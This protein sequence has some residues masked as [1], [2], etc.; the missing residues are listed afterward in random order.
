MTS[1]SRLVRLPLLTVALAV[2]PSALAAQLREGDAGERAAY[3]R[4]LDAYPYADEPPMARI[5]AFESLRLDAPRAPSV[6]QPGGRGRFTQLGPFAVVQTDGFYLSAPQ[7]DAGRVTSIALHPTLP[8]TYYAGTAGG[9]LWKTTNGGFTWQALTD[10]ECGKDIG[11]VVVD[12][13]N[14]E[15]VYAGMGNRVE[16]P[17]QAC[18]LLR[19]T[20]GGESWTRL[21]ATQFNQRR[22]WAMH[23]DP[24]TAGSVSSAVLLVG[25]DIGLWRSTNGGTAFTQVRTG[26]HSAVAGH[27]ANGAIM[28]AARYGF[29]STPAEVVRSTD[30]GAT[31]SVIADALPVAEAGRVEL[32]TSAADPDALWI[33]AERRSDARLLGLYRWHPATGLTT[34]NASGLFPGGPRLDFGAQTW[35]NLAL[36]VDPVDAQRIYLGGVRAYRSNDGGN[37]F[38]EMARSI[39]VDWHTIVVHPTDPRRIFAGNDGGLVVSTDRGDNFTTRNGGMATMMFYPGIAVHPTIPGY[40]LG[41]TQDNGSM[42]SGFFTVFEGVSGGDGGFAAINPQNPSIMWTT[43]QQAGALGCLYR[44]SG[45]T[46]VNRS[47]GISVGDRHGF[48]APLVMSPADPTRLYYGTQRLWRTTNEGLAWN[49]RSGDLT[50]G[51]GVITTIVEAPSASGVVWVGTSDGKVW[52]SAD[53]TDTWSDVSAGLPDR[54]VSKVAVDAT[55]PDRAYVAIGG[56]GTSKLWRTTN[57]GATWEDVGAGLPDVPGRAALLIPGTQRVFYAGDL[58]VWESGTGAPP[59]TRTEGLPAVRTNDLAYQAP[60]NLVIAATFGRGLWSMDIGPQNTALRG[61]IN[62]DGTVNAADALLIQ[63]VIAGQ[64]LTPPL[65]A[66]PHGDANCDGVVNAVDAL[67]VLR[68]AVGASVGGACVGSVQ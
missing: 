3:W 26:L 17:G 6:P 35:W 55:N 7:P 32:A 50:K 13:V 1:R 12:P 48:I 25:N 15:I 63:R 62:R 22:T 2:A 40:V 33:A 24:R 5:R 57:R 60:F 42:R 64:A 66:F 65:T 53:A 43:C 61:D 9:G 41:G 34:L 52:V 58:G 30:G 10:N 4:A 51:S 27:P 20:N 28:Y 46:V 45:S 54:A 23:L 44:V 59:W 37:S 36:A 8:G 67:L 47:T 14:P 29:A 16:S 49:A 19:S 38:T 11:A 18:G 39:H 56:F 68:F 31:W 21:A